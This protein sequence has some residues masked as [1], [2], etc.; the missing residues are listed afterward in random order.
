MEALV[1]RLA[2]ALLAV[3]VTACATATG[4]VAGG[5]TRFDAAPAQFV[6]EGGG[7][8]TTW[9]ALYKELFGP[10]ARASCSSAV[11]CHGTSNSPGALNSGGF[12]CAAKDACLASL[13]STE[14]GLLKDEDKSAPDKSGLY[15]IL[16]RQE[17]GR[18]VGL[19]PKSPAYVFTP[20]ELTRLKTWIANGAPND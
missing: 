10:G 19:M 14:T 18:T 1:P 5:E 7:T 15:G 8:A 3:G 4:D 20:D 13:K 2:A 11:T 9:S 16:R 6:T 12:V 17:G